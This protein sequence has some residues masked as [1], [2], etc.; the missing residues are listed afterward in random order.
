MSLLNPEYNTRS[1]SSRPEST[2][3]NNQVLEAVNGI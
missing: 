2:N 3:D 1:S